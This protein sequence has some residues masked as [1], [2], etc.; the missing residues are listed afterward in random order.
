M[1]NKL[2]ITIFLTIILLI[3]DF[4]FAKIVNAQEGPENLSNLRILYQGQ[5]SDS[6]GNPI[7]DGKYNIRFRIY[8]EEEWGN[9][10][11]Q[12]E[13]TFYN[14]ISVKEGQFKI[15]LGRENPINLN[16]DEAPFWLGI[17]IGLTAPEGISWEEE[18]QPR[19]KIT[20][21]SELLGVEELTSEQ[22]ENLS[23]LIKEKL[24]EE[25]DIVLL[26]DLSQLENLETGEGTDFSAS[27]IS[28]FQNFVNFISEK[29]SE[30]GEKLN[31]ILAKIDSIISTLT[32][33]VNTLA[34]MKHK[35]D[36]LYE[37]LI[38]QQGLEPAGEKNELACTPNWSCTEWWPLS[39]TVAC[40]ES[41]TQTRTCTDLNSCS[42]AQISEGNLG[43]QADEGKPIVEQ[44]T[45]GTNT[46][47]CGLTFCDPDGTL[48]LIGQCP[49]TCLKGSCQSCTPTCT[50]AEGFSDCD[51]DM[52]NGCETSGDCQ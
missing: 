52:T 11:W 47:N 39:E 4:C 48:H 2:L 19:K 7:A 32:N 8:D 10:L 21:L 16:L 50:C 43:G 20:T 13:Y 30:I 15:I 22:W 51:S 36:V 49:D 38:V 6:E 34:E 12:E 25:T 17:S 44:K 31:Q 24:G 23:Q 5:L 45:A 33:I 41:F 37:V 42:P 1:N 14:A 29:I 3:G 26:F 40:G 46:E 35:I 27:M 28:F 18:I 9:I